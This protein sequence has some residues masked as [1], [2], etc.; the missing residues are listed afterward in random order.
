MDIAIHSK[1][2]SEVLLAF[3]ATRL[4]AFSVSL[5]A[6]GVSKGLAAMILCSCHW[7]ELQAPNQEQSRDGFL[8]Q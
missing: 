7:F 5:Q 1:T 2:A 8:Q 3:K 6:P 4:L